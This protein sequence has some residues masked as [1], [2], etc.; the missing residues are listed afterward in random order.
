MSDSTQQLS[1]L[2]VEDEEIVRTGYERTLKRYSKDL[3]IAN[4]GEEGLAAYIKHSPDIVISDINMPKMNGIEMVEEIRK[5][6]KNQII[7]FTTAHTEAKYTLAALAMQVDAYL[8]KPI[9]KNELQ[10]KISS[11]SEIILNYREK[12]KNQKIIQKILD[13]QSHV[14]V[15][16]NFET[17]EFA[18]SSFYNLFGIKKEDEFTKK[19]P[20]FLNMFIPYKNY[21]YAKTKEKF[22]KKYEKSSKS[23]RVVSIAEQG[24]KK[25]FHINIDPIDEDDLYIMS[26]TDISTFEEE[27]REIKAKASYDKLTLAFNRG[28]FD[29]LFE[30]EYKR[31]KRYKRNLSIAILDIDNFKMINDTHGHLVGD[32]ILQQLV[33][34][35]MSNIR[36]TDVFA[37]WGGE[38]FVLLMSE[39]SLNTAQLV[40][41][42]L[43]KKIEDMSHKNLP[44]IT[45]SF[46][47]TQIKTEDTKETLFS[48]AD[49][50]LYEAKE[51]G[52]NRVII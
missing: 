3:Y 31:A 17:I 21:L 22:I 6:K 44:K 35:C 25:T 16:T 18:S 46:G 41:E 48:R 38:E 10:L 13:N 26:L 2:Y 1:I 9:N 5:I 36:K 30:I 24:T 50:S 51:N 43:R 23:K 11:L 47:L 8:I 33:K 12:I 28:K 40:C 49:R 32:K 20:N 45:A 52:K 42:S 39:T 7:I 14:T 27:K 4:D 19:F 37:R 29:E 34:T 15:L